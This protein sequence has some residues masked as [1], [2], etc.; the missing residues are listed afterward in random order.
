[1]MQLFHKLFKQTFFK[2]YVWLTIL[3]GYQLIIPYVILPYLLSSLGEDGYGQ[4]A[5]SLSIMAY[6]IS[7]VD[8]GFHMYGSRQIALLENDE[9]RQ[10]IFFMHVIYTKIGLFLVGSIMM[11]TIISFFPRFQEIQTLLFIFLL[12]VFSYVLNPQ[13]YLIGKQKIKILAIITM[14]IKI[15]YV[16]L[17]FIFVKDMSDLWFYA[18]IYSAMMVVISLMNFMYVYIKYHMTFIKIQITLIMKNIKDAFPL[19]STSLMNQIFLVFGTFYLGFIVSDSLVGIYASLL[20]ISSIIVIIYLPLSDAFLPYITKVF[21]K[22][23]QKGIQNHRT[24]SY[25]VSSVIIIVASVIFL[26]RFWIFDVLLSF[27]TSDYDIIFSMMLMIQ[28]LGLII[29]ISSVQGLI[30]LGK[31]RLYQKIYLFMTLTFISL[32]VVLGQNYEIMGVLI[33]H[34]MTFVIGAIAFGITLRKSYHIALERAT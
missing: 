31:E 26:F 15:I 23:L 20:K 10:K 25:I 11:I 30:A 29:N 1:M 34:L 4:L 7:F 3:Y 14:L 27:D 32:T 24:F 21:Q 13:F 33:A 22:D 12:L 9:Q 19:F 6:L 8:Y 18:M 16:F 17:V 28:I 5:F 2:Q